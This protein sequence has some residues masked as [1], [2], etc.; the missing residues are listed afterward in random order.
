MSLLYLIGVV[1]FY[2]T[3][4]KVFVMRK[5]YCTL[6]ISSFLIVLSSS[7]YAKDKP[8][9]TD[10][11]IASVAVVANQSDISYAKVALDKS[12]NTDIKEFANTM[13]K[14]HSAVINQAVALVKKLSVTPK[15][16]EVSK[17]LEKQATETLKALNAA[18]AKD[19]DKV[20][21]DNEVK[22]HEAVISAVKSLLIPESNN[23][24]LKGLLEGVLPVLEMHLKHAQMVQQK[25]S[26]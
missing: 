11:E 22:Y 21:I 25:V 14:D 16:N 20:Y 6:I 24:E 10:P 12:H 4:I 13:I 8:K 18:S 19:F 3:K 15:S 7:A 2:K 17:S 5:L 23:P 26:K 1:K 9:L